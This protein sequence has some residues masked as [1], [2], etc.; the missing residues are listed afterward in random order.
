MSVAEYY[1]QLPKRRLAAGAV[2]TNSQR[3]VLMVEPTYKSPW[4]VPGGSVEHGESPKGACIRECRE[5]LGLDINVGRLLVLE[6]Q[7][8][9]LPR[10]DSG[11]FLYDGGSLGESAEITLPADELRS[12]AYVD[13]MQLYEVTSARLASRIQHAL[14]ALAAGDTVE[15]ET[16]R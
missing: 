1:L 9:A 6:H 13:P 3:H 15:L 8:E 16:Q 12:F 14:S 10:G 5:E 11:M 7:L 4:E 2:I